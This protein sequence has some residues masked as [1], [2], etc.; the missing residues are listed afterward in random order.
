MRYVIAV[1]PLIG[2]QIIGGSYFLVIGKSLPSL[3]LN[4]SRQFLI[5]IP[6]L[7]ILPGF[8]GLT[9]LLV[10]FP[11]ADFLATIITVVWLLAEL[12]RKSVV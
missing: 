7:L 1:F 11:I 9:G 3:I 5:L 12:D 8:F 4:L 10:S 6:L 2:I